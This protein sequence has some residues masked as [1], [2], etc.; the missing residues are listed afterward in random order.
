[1]CL[2]T[3]V[4]FDRAVSMH[5]LMVSPRARASAA[6]DNYSAVVPPV[7]TLNICA[8]SP[9]FTAVCGMDIVTFFIVR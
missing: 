9:Q 5:F 7:L 1:M 4:R 3:T 6:R 8:Y 2:P